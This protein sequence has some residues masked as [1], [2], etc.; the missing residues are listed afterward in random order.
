MAMTERRALG[1]L[2][3]TALLALAWLALPFAMGLLLGALLAF[4]LEPFYLALARRT[5]RP[6]TA[7]L[8]TVMAAAVVIVSAVAGF[9]SLFI[10]RVADLAGAT[11]EALQPG[12]TLTMWVDAVGSWLTRVGFSPESVTTRLEEG[13]GAVASGSAAVAG[14]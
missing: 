8:T 6:L 10:S 11:R 2:A 5:H 9:V 1:W 3:V 13:A 4:T 12:G 14:S 7:V